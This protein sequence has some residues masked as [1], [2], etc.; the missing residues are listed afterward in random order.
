MNF[1]SAADVKAVHKLLVKSD[2]S[3]NIVTFTLSKLLLILIKLLKIPLAKNHLDI[4]KT[5]C[6]HSNQSL[7]LKQEMYPCVKIC[8]AFVLVDLNV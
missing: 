1:D 6:I 7:T 5:P 3:S 4:S 2:Q 8:V